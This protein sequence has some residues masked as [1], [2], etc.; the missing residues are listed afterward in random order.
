MEL[1][2]SG[3]MLSEGQLYFITKNLRQKEQKVFC[4]YNVKLL[5]L[6]AEKIWE[7]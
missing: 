7:C 3:P 5:L 6:S 4:I 1:H 2:N